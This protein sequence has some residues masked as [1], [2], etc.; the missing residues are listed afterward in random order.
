[1]IG[2]LPPR[3]RR[4]V[5]P[6][7]GIVRS[8]EEVL[9]STA[10]APLFQAS[11]ELA[12]GGGLFG[13][14]LAHVGG[15]GGVGGTRAEA[16]AAAVGEAIER[17]SATYVPR[18][19]LVVDSASRLGDVA[20]APSR[21]ALFSER[22]YAQP[23]FPYR[24]FTADSTIAWIEGYSL[25]DRRPAFLPAELVF[26]GDARTAGRGI[27]YSTSSGLACA[28]TVEE[29]T[30]R[31]LCEVLERDAFML[32]WKNR[33]SLPVLDAAADP[34]T[35]A[36]LAAFS[37]PGLPYAA[38]DLSSI[39]RFPIV[40]AVVRAPRFAAGALGVGAAAAPT[41][42]RAA[43]KALSEAFATRSAGVKL[44]VVRRGRAS[45]RRGETVDTFDDHIVH[46][47]DHRRAAATAFLDSSA[48]RT[49]AA[50]VSPLEGCT[51]TE[52]IAAL[53]KRVGA[54]RSS[55]YAVDVTSPDV[56]EL[57]LTVTRVI[58]PELCPLDVSHST[59][60]L[61]GVRLYG[62]AAALGLREHVLEESDIN[63]DP[64]P[65]P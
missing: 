29:A 41:I 57:G 34:S 42:E 2:T 23:G 6:Y 20:V 18:E 40:L 48:A 35:R 61:G 9:A 21:F 22:Q 11:C 16:A 44:E 32:V 10:D 62:A 52:Q 19:R 45:D 58:A 5:S 55:A 12:S 30:T 13:T 59:R 28:D 37:E 15:V 33:L 4:A 3:L 24:P 17:Y 51:A 31:G 25:P 47:A 14:D 56:A 8:V 1:M 26:L 27:G 53:C 43:W 49:L 63:P 46:Y 64:H 38:V 54:A 50:D 60:F 7:T 36:A 65:F 39:H